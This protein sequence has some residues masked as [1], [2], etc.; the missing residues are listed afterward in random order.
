MLKELK[1]KR[2][3]S[4]HSASAKKRRTLKNSKTFVGPSIIRGFLLVEWGRGS[5]LNS[6]D[7]RRMIAFKKATRNFSQRY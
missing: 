5:E 1:G 3:S 7:K 6:R 2:S 4:H